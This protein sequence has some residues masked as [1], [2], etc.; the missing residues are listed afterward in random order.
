[1]KNFR[2]RR[3]SHENQP[4]PG[5][6][7]FPAAQNQQNCW[8]K[9]GAAAFIAKTLGMCDIRRVVFECVQ[10]TGLSSF[11]YEVS[12]VAATRCQVYGEVVNSP[13]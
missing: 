1:M 11:L 7:F 5:G 3:P 10:T 8:R 13:Q 4:K 6:R 9:E 12:L 2:S